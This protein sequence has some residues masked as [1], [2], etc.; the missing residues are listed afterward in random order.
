M[1]RC[2]FRKGP[3]LFKG[4]KLREL[5]ENRRGV[6]LENG[7][8]EMTKF[9]ATRQA[10]AALSGTEKEGVKVLQHVMSS[11]ITSSLIP[12]SGE[13][14]LRDEREL[15]TLAQALDALMTGDPG[16]AGDVLMQRVCGVEAAHLEGDGRLAQHLEV[17]PPAGSSSV[18]ERVREELAQE[19]LW[20][21][22]RRPG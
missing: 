20:R 11:Y 12:A 1:N 21:Q 10:G 19:K 2:F 8:K 17:V 7:V 3:S 16:R 14:R 13:M 6:F 15:R 9:L 4:S 22:S 18:P 5:S